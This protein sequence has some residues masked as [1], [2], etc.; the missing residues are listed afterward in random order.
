MADLERKIDLLV[1]KIDKLITSGGRPNTTSSNFKS[2]SSL[3]SESAD[4]FNTIGKGFGNLFD[5][6]ASFLGK[7]RD[8]TASSAD[9]ASAVSKTISQLT[10][11]IPGLSKF[12]TVL[13]GLTGTLI[14][15]VNNWKQFSGLGL[16]F[17]G[18]AIALNTAIKRTGMTVEEYAASWD[19]LGPA[20]ANLGLGVT[21]GTQAFGTLS[22]EMLKPEYSDQFNKLGMN[23]KDTNAALAMVMR[24]ANGIIDINKLDAEGKN[25]LLENTVRLSKEMDATAKLSGKSREAQ[26]KQIEALQADERVRARI[27]MN[28][29]ENPAA[30]ADI[31]KAQSIA[32]S[33]LDPATAKLINEGIAG[34]GILSSDAIVEFRKVFGPEAATKVS[35]MTRDVNSTDAKVREKAL[36]DLKGFSLEL[37]RSRQY[38]ARQVAGG[39]VSNEFSQQGLGGINNQYDMLERAIESV[40][41]EPKNS[42]MTDQEALNEARARIK[43]EQQGKV[44][45]LTAEDV[46]NGL[47]VG[48]QRPTQQLTSTVTNI[49]TDIKR[50][51]V[52]LN[53][54]IQSIST[55]VGQLKGPKGTTLATSVE[56][57]TANVNKQG[58]SSV[59]AYITALN[60]E[61]TR[62]D[63]LPEKFGDKI[64]EA[65]LEKIKGITP[66]RQ[67]GSLGAKGQWFENFGA[68]SL[69]MLHGPESVVREDQA[70]A[71]AMSRMNSI[72]PNLSKVMQKATATVSDSSGEADQIASA[73]SKLTTSSMPDFTNLGD[74]IDKLNSTFASLGPVFQQIARNTGDAAKNTKD[75]GNYV[76]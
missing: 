3:G 38:G 9:A 50:F 62:L 26:E 33:T 61:I 63:K 76:S 2:S 57:T 51:S 58:L 69:T 72:L 44:A 75:L 20:I 24:S 21:Q 66:G 17:G 59:T 64:G 71:F 53:E 15:S 28:R 22:Q 68:G 47:K 49:D 32:G 4:F 19:K 8:N 46:A 12:S 65:I 14:D 52:G 1:D 34:K 16:Q 60:T 54:M 74:G 5:T 36:E 56:A 55:A 48:M 27:L 7:A 35:Q 40:K 73:I 25:S 6:S 37:M 11:D 30:N 70:D 29:R 67:G 43:L 23:T 42:G 13:D 41:N 31:G 10:A 18:D 39:A 45:V